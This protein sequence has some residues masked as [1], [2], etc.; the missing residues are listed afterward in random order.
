MFWRYFFSKLSN[1]YYLNR[2]NDFTANTGNGSDYD[3]F[4][5]IL[6]TMVKTCWFIARNYD[7]LLCHLLISIFSTAIRQTR[8]LPSTL[9]ELSMNIKVFTKRILC[10]IL[11]CHV[12]ANISIKQLLKF[13]S[14]TWHRTKLY[15][16][17]CSIKQF[18]C[19]N[20]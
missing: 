13:D 16:V 12:F 19:V 9:L 11:L 6:S 15:F 14:R 2:M 5:P 7:P 4:F 1:T 17:H 8:K 20:N 18:I 3:S 10:E